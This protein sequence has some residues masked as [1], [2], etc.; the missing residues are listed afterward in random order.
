MV[1]ELRRRSGDTLPA[2]MITGDTST[3]VAE[4]GADHRLR[5]ASKTVNPDA[6]LEI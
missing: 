2:V 5:I 3:A 1:S 6:L 4:L